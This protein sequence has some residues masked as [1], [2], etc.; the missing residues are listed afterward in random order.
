MMPLHYVRSQ[1]IY[2]KWQT[3]FAGG[4]GVWSWVDCMS[5][6]EPEQRKQRNA[7]AGSR[8]RV[9]SMGGL[10]DAATLRAL[11]RAPFEFIKK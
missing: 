3:Y 10:Y 1:K 6:Q 4:S 8:T 11:T 7:H 9:T 2:S 5:W